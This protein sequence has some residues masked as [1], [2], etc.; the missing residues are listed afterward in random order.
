MRKIALVLAS[1]STVAALGMAQPASAEIGGICNG[2][3]DAD[4]VY[5]SYEYDQYL[6]CTLW[7]N[8]CQVG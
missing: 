8:G 1:L 6:Y 4:C 3:V 2:A 7:V 5:W